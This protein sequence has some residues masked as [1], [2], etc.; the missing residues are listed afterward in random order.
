MDQGEA[1][2]GRMPEPEIR[3]RSGSDSEVTAS[4][5]HV[6]FPPGSGQATVL[7]SDEPAAFTSLSL[8]PLR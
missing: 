5:S 6:R 2:R 1:L 8:L 4:P 7:P 3:V